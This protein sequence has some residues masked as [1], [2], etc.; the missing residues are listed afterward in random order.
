MRGYVCTQQHQCDCENDHRYLG[1]EKRYRDDPKRKNNRNVADDQKQLP[2]SAAFVNLPLF[3][4]V[5]HYDQEC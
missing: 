2:V 5:R 1:V 3:L 4:V